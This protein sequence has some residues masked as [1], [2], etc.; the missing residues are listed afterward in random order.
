MDRATS[1]VKALDLLSLLGGSGSGFRIQELAE[2][3]NLPRSTVVRILNTLV[4]YGFVEKSGHN[5]RCSGHFGLWARND[6]LGLLRARYRAALESVARDT[7]ELVVLGVQEGAG[8]IHIDMVEAD[9]AVRV[10]PAPATHHTPRHNAIGKLCI[11]Q[12]PDLEARWTRHDPAFAREL[13]E[14]RERGVAWNREET[15][16]GM[17]ALACYGFTRAVTEPKVAVA[18]PLR[19]FRPEKGEAA[20]AAIRRALATGP[21]GP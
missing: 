17:I 9:R 2:A 20:I 16:P 18:W 15:V 6:R 19:R 12:R 4:E 5:Y 7:G 8:I 1:L 14:I 10:A 11:A 21:R 3:M 13:R